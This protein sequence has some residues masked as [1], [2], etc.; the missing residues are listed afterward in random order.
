MFFTNEAK[1]EM[2]DKLVELGLTE[3]EA[4]HWVTLTELKS[5]TPL[6]K[7]EENELETISKKIAKL[8]KKRGGK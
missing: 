6:C 4:S 1:F 7:T 8:N 3:R 5:N 2:M